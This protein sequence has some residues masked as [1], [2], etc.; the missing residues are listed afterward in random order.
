MILNLNNIIIFIHYIYLVSQY[1]YVNLIRA[2]SAFTET[3][4]NVWN[5]STKFDLIQNL[6][7]LSYY[8]KTYHI[9]N[10]SATFFN[11]KKNVDNV[12]N[13]FK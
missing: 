9:F 11:K 4:R 8:N 2:K 10:G 3:M 7:A 13:T 12:L 1:Y 6:C 5:L